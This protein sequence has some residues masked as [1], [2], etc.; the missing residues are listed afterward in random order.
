MTTAE[1]APSLSAA[2]RLLR[3]KAVE[4][5]GAMR[6]VRRRV[7]Q[8]HHLLPTVIGL[9]PEPLAHCPATLGAVRE[10]LGT[11]CAL[12]TLRALSAAQLPQLPTPLGF[13]RHRCGVGDRKPGFQHNRGHDPPGTRRVPSPSRWAMTR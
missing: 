7:R 13:R 4:L 2:A 3:P 12:E 10:R 11:D 8:V 9:L 6:W 1:D 5:S